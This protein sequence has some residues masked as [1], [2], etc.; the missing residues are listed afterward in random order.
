MIKKLAGLN[1]AQQLAFVDDSVGMFETNM[2]KA[3]L[4][5]V[6]TSAIGLVKNMVEY[7]IPDDGLF[8]IQDNPWMM[9]INWE[10]Q[11]PRLREY[12]WGVQ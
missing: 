7:R 8:T 10:E 4:I 5:R 11:L 6:G 1:I 9:I 3:D 12:I 2:S